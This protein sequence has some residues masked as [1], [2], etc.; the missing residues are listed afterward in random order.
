[1]GGPDAGT[2]CLRGDPAGPPR[3]PGDCALPPARRVDQPDR[4]RSGQG[5][6]LPASR[7]VDRRC[8]HAAAPPRANPR[9]SPDRAVSSPDHRTR[10]P[11]DDPG[12][13]DA[14]DGG[15]SIV[16][17]G[18]QESRWWAWARRTAYWTRRCAITASS[19]FSDCIGTVVPFGAV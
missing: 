17:C 5:V 6:P 11:P 9:R 14:D 4:G 8:L 19:T 15:A 16:T 7:G 12:G 2:Y 13:D 10:G 1:A 3:H 18:G